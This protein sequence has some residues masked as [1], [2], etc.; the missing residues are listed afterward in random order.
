MQLSTTP[1]VG[2]SAGS[3][4]LWEAGWTTDI[5]EPNDAGIAKELQFDQEARKRHRP[6]VDR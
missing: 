3:T 6:Q 4:L 2:T 1:D 5:V